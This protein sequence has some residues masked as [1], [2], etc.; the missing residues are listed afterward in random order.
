MSD[1]TV[2]SS[3]RSILD[4]IRNVNNR[5]A[6]LTLKTIN[7]THTHEDLVEIRELHHKLDKLN[8]EYD[9]ARRLLDEQ[10]RQAADNDPAM[11]R[12]RA[13]ITRRSIS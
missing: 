4:S 12:A 7:K 8:K 9:A 5:L 1:T 3:W 11:Q 6:L 10:Q 13:N 2:R